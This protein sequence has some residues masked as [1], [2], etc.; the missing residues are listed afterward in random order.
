MERERRGEGTHPLSENHLCDGVDT[1]EAFAFNCNVNESV[2]N[3][4]NQNK[5]EAPNLTLS[6]SIRNDLSDV[7]H[8]SGVEI[9]QIKMDFTASLLRL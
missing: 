5:E 6:S 3:N 4:K 9:P 1:M 2:E 8:S 7:M